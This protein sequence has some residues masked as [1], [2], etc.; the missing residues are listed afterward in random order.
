[1]KLNI[2][3]IINVTKQDILKGKS[4]PEACPVTLGIKKEFKL[5]VDDYVFVDEAEIRIGEI[6]NLKTPKDVK[7]FIKTFDDCFD[8]NGHLIDRESRNSLKPFKFA[9][10]L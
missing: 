3:K 4:D 1:M 7:T 8:Y 10:E 9:L 2:K 6:F 5:T